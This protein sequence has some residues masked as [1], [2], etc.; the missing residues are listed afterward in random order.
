ML[1]YAFDPNDMKYFHSNGL[2]LSG[3]FFDLYVAAIDQLVRA[4]ERGRASMLTIGMHLRI[5]G[6]PARFTAVETILE[7]LAAPVEQAYIAT[8][9]CIVSRFATTVG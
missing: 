5:S 7:R 4:T 9:Q 8:R 2:C 6:R 3:R 1:P